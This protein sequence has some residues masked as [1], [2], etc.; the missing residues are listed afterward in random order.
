VTLFVILAIAG[1]AFF[2]VLGFGIRSAFGWV[3]LPTLMLVPA[4]AVFDLPGLPDL[5]PG[6]GV[7]IGLIAGA[8]A[9]GDGRG[10]LP[11]WRWIDA[12]ALL[13]VVSFAVSY[14]EITDF[15]GF[16]SRLAVLLM[17]WGCPYLFARALISDVVALRALL[18]P[19]AIFACVLAFLAVYESRMA[20]RLAPF[21]WNSIGVAL[22]PIPHYGSWRWGF[23]RAHATFYGP[24]Q[25]GTFFAMATPLALLWGI[26]EPRYR[27]WSWLATLMCAGGC[28]ASMSRGPM[29]ILPAVTLICWII[30]RPRQSTILAALTV[31]ICSAP[32]LVEA[33][34]EE[35]RYTSARVEATGNTADESGHYRIALLLIYGKEIAE[36][37]WLGDPSIV[38]REYEA[39]W[40]IDNAYLYLFLVGGW[41]GGGSICLLI[42]VTFIQT[43]RALT[44]ATGRD[45]WIITALLAAFAG[46]TGCMANVWFAVDYAPFFWSCQAIL[47]NVVALYSVRAGMMAEPEARIS[48]V[49]RRSGRDNRSVPLDVIHG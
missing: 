49:S 41:I 23:L 3:Y 26:L 29:Y 6:R 37:G 43:L 1:L 17:D 25:L 47:Y 40:S 15:K 45:R 5:T 11:R 28:V 46:M 27:K 33:A 21:L 13:P 38:G 14:G 31:L 42:L 48:R 7:A 8:I 10:L 32:F 20:F 24:I 12:L 4:R 34:T 19:F 39:T 35:V 16:Y 2:A 9:T 44:G 36:V 30:A 22:E 18:K